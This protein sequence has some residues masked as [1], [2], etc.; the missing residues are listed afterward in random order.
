MTK[1]QEKYFELR[2]VENITSFKKIANYEDVTE[3]I[4]RD[5]LKVLIIFWKK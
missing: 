1:E 3:S 5:R 4:I 2:F